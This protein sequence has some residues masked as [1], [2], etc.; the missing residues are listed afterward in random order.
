MPLLFAYNKVRFS[1]IEVKF[2]YTHYIS[3]KQ[4]QTYKKEFFYSIYELLNMTAQANPVSSVIKMLDL[5]TG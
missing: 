2:I 4:L 1:G 5:Y 3:M